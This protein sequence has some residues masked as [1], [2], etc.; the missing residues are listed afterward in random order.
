M[1]ALWITGSLVLLLFAVALGLWIRQIRL[2]TELH[3]HQHTI[4]QLRADKSQL[5]SENQR[6]REV[7]AQVQTQILQLSEDKARLE[8]ELR[9]FH[10]H[11]EDRK[12]YISEVEQKLE[13]LQKAYEAALQEISQ[14][15]TQLQTA[16]ANLEWRDAQTKQLETLFENL[17]HRLIRTGT[18]SLHDW[19]QESLSALLQPFRDQL[20]SLQREMRDY[21]GKQQE[22][23]GR[24]QA[25]IDR[26]LQDSVKL[27]QQTET[28]TRALRGDIRV[29][30][31]WG[32]SRLK[33]LLDLAGFKEGEQYRTQLVLQ[34]ED[35]QSLR[36]DV[37]FKLPDNRY[38]L[39]DAKVTIT[40]YD[41][42]FAAT[43]EEEQKKALQELVVSVRK[44]IK[45]LHKYQKVKIPHIGWTI[46]FC[47]VEG[48]LQAALQSDLTLLND[49]RESRVILT[50]PFILT[51]FIHLIGQLW[52]YEKRSRYAEEIALLAQKML[53]KLS[54]F[55]EEM[56]KVGKGLDKAKQTY[57]SAH[58]Y[59]I[60]GKENV[61]ALA[62]RIQD[63]GVPVHK[64]FPEALVEAALIAEEQA[65]LT[66]PSSLP[67]K[68][69]DNP[70]S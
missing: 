23:M 8:G 50:G 44:H 14:L 29:Q 35:G 46:L 28:L 48:A 41:S 61:I 60:S 57:E 7:H 15:Q 31:R 12:S 45:E 30:G 68:A 1:M 2:I 62:K 47:P 70:L 16:E 17:M 20:E 49:A 34:S 67:A 10:Q 11:W 32:E 58:R 59:L 24:L 13:N 55:V 40:A 51:G 38:I 52:Q 64:A 6:L 27:T 65:E 43:T 3:Q 63:H 25:F 39:I 53:D 19:S 56:E 54:R 9:T 5:Q 33:E 4:D 21:N 37:V 36:P 42:Y 18:Q 22:N 66:S 69:S 26:F